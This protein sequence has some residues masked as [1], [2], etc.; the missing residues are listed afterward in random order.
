M[1]KDI[2]YRLRAMFRRGSVEQELDDEIRF[3]LEREAEKY[4][5]SGVDP[6]DAM[7]RARLA[8]GGVDNTKEESREARGTARIESIVQDLR[9]SMRSLR[10]QPHFTVAV[11]LTLALGIGAN[12][13]LYSLVD[14]LMLRTLPVPQPERLVSIGDPAAV[15]QRWSGSPET[16]YVSYPLYVDV[17]DHNNVLSGLYAN[18]SVG[19]LDVTFAGA[20]D[21]PEHPEA[22]FVSGNFFSVLQVSAELGR[23]FG[24]DEDR[25][26]QNPVAV[27]NYDYFQRRFGGN[28]SVIGSVLRVN[29]VRATVVGVMSKQFGSG[30]IVGQPVD[31]W[32]PIAAEAVFKPR[33]DLIPRRDVSWLVLVGRLA[34]GVT[35]EQAKTTL[36]AIE[37]RAVRATLAGTQLVE[38]NEDM[39][40]KPIR[41]ELA[42]RGLSARREQYARALSVLMIA[43]ILVTLVVCANVSN[44]MLARGLARTREMTVRMAL[45]A[46]QGR[47]MQQVITEGA[48]LAAAAG[49]LGLVAAMAGGRLLL[50]TV[51]GPDRRTTLDLTMNARLLCFTGGLTLFCL[52]LFAL[53][54]AVRAGRVD[55][56]AA[57]RASGRNL[58]G[59]RSRIGRCSTMTLLVAVQIAL[60]MVLVVGSGLLAR[61]M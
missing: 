1:L 46:G 47:L 8:F 51:S 2:R 34:P 4:V 24:P 43:V 6:A 28:R 17:R 22:R 25:V 44:L 13:A 10:H 20:A 33:A 3:H 57:L 49:A 31:M 54:P 19:D 5:R 60:A 58:S 41:V 61:S 11:V 39:A 38:F 52:L 18:G 9:Y 42:P 15:N 29:G 45:G 35:L 48:L 40:H 21:E 16:D 53:A 36:P 30:D 14:A 56:A 32:F 55:L 59:A 37:A 27:L 26:G 23:T 7:R 12:V 50:A